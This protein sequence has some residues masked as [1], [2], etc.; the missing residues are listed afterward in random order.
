MASLDDIDFNE[1]RTVSRQVS[2]VMIPEGSRMN[3]EQGTEVFITQALGGS[4]TVNANGILVRVGAQDVD[5][6]GFDPI[7]LPAHQAA[8]ANDGSIDESLVWEQ[9]KT[10]YDPEIPINVVDLGLI[11]KCEIKREAD[12]NIIEIEMTLTAP[13]CGMGPFLIEDVREKVALVPNVDEVQVELV[14]DPPWNY[15]MMSEAA[16][17]E[18]GML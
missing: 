13:G 5:A 9:M 18:T 10:C 17:L 3:L 4:V 16:R 8:A 2:V 14:F 11:Y 6:L 1:P 12:K 7:E 15:E